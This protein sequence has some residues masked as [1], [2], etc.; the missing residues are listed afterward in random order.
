MRSIQPLVG[1]WPFGRELPQDICVFERHF[2]RSAWANPFLPGVV[3]QYREVGEPSAHVH[4]HASGW[5]R[6]DHVD[7]HN[8]DRGLG[9][10]IK[11]AVADTWWGAPL[12]GLG[13]SMYEPRS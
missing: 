6:I 8:P 13:G 11:H 9:N 1:P 3:A 7:Q 12:A 2:R 5:W 10:A 4:V